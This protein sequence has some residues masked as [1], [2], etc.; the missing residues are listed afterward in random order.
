MRFI[1]IAFLR[2]VFRLRLFSSTAVLRLP[3]SIIAMITIDAAFFYF[4]RY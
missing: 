3:P 1:A 2:R 4:R